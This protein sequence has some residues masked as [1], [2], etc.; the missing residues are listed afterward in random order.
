MFMQSD[1]AMGSVRPLNIKR[2]VQKLL[3]CLCAL[4]AFFAKPMA[5]SITR[6]MF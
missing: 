2:S 5:E 1:A 3:A 4:F 6:H